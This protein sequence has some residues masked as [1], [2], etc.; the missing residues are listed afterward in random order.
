MMSTRRESNR[1]FWLGRVAATAI[2]VLVGLGLFAGSAAAQVT[3]YEYDDAA[4]WWAYFDCDAMKMIIP[5]AEDET[6]A[7]HEERACSPT[8]AGLE[9]PER[10]AIEDFID[11]LE[12]GPLK[13]AEAFWDHATNATCI[14]RA[15]I[16]G[17]T[18]LEVA[19][20]TLETAADAQAPASGSRE[21]VLYCVAYDDLGSGDMTM[22]N[23]IAMALSGVDTTDED[24]EAPALPLVGVGLLGLL[25]AGRGAWLRRRNG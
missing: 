11:S 23:M 20:V 19:E 6:S 5:A 14:N 2:M 10:R 25:L 22:V 15:R 13:N 7:K 3:F 21:E 1:S 16:V 4:A 8:L 12:N 18:G 24:E 9:R 17:K